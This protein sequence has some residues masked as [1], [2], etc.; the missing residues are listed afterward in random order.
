MHSTLT[1]SILLFAWVSLLASSFIVSEQVLPYASPVAATWLRFFLTSIILLPLVRF[2]VDFK[3]GVKQLVKYAV[4]SL[5]IVLFFVGLFE[6]LKTTT[7]QRTAVIYTL[8]P[9]ICVLL[10]YFLLQVVPKIIQLLGFL[11]GIFGAIWTLLIADTE[12]TTNW[13]SGDSLFLLSC[14]SLA[15][16]VVLTK[17]WASTQ[18]ALISTFMIVSLGSLLLLPPFILY[19]N[20]Q[21]I[22]WGNWAFWFGIIYLTLFTTLGT[23]FLQQYLLKRFS[24]NVFLAATYLVPVLVI[25]FQGIA[26]LEVLLTCLPA[27]LIILL[28]LYL[29]SSKA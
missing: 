5:F 10:S 11:L 20:P 9:L 28:A 1:Q 24:P 18:R 16:H 8:L 6:S 2:G 25:L 15:L 19:G 3:I 26:Q 13:L 23:F 4:V 12:I 21:D 22:A 14:F 27:L 29:I 17:K 7:A